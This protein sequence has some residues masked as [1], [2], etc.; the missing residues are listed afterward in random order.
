MVRYRLLK[1]CFSLL[2]VWALATLVAAS[3]GAETTSLS[4]EAFQ[5]AKQ[6]T[7]G[8]LAD[9][10]DQRMPE[11]QKRFPFEAREFTCETATWLPPGT[12]RK[13]MIQRPA[14]SF[15]NESVS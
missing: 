3:A 10:Q 14:P 7:V 5:R 15:R 11:N 9:T 1:T 12:Q 2:C 8:I 6:V 13:S 4:Q